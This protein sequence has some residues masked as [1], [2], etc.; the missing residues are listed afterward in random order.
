MHDS[1]FLSVWPFPVGKIFFGR[2]LRG[3][4]HATREALR[5]SLRHLITFDLPKSCILARVAQA[6]FYHRLLPPIMSG[7]M[8]SFGAPSVDEQK[9]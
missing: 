9:R 6:G 1:A 7:Q 4:V 3:P 2:P 5:A 8:A